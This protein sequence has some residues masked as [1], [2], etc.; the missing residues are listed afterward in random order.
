MLIKNE[1][2]FQ[3]RYVYTLCRIDKIYN[4]FEDTYF[5]ILKDLFMLNC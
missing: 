1:K 5:C 4:V 3:I 2:Y